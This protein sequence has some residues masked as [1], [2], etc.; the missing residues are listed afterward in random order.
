MGNSKI[1][2]RDDEKKEIIDFI[3]LKEK[4]SKTLFVSGQPGTGKTSLIVEILNNDLS[5][6][7]EYFL[8]FSINCLS[9]NSTDDFYDAVFK[10]MNDA[11]IYNYLQEILEEKK[12]NHLIKLLKENPSQNSFLKILNILGKTPF[13]I[14]L[15]EID[16]LYKRKD[17]FLFFSLLTIPYLTNTG[18]KMILISN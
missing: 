10:Y 5:E 15:D 1:F 9:I 7:K 18:V 17:D 4:N 11:T 16:F 12:Y 3:K 13:I 14:L 8:K 6:N 2:C